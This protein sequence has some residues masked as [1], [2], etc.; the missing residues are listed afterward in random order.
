MLWGLCNVW[1]PLGVAQ[2]FVPGDVV[3]PRVAHLP[4]Q[5]GRAAR[6]LKVVCDRAFYVLDFGTGRP[7]RWY[8]DDE[9]MLAPPGVEPGQVVA[10]HLVWP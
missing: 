8:A 7:H 10:A 6:V 1:C 2:H 5:Q 3:V 9:L 4:E